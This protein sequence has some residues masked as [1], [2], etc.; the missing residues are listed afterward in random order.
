MMLHSIHR[1]VNRK[2]RL[3]I[4]SASFSLGLFSANVSQAQ[5]YTNVYWNPT[6]NG[7]GGTGLWASSSNFWSTNIAGGGTLSAPTNNFI[8]NFSGT[9]GTVTSASSLTVGGINFLTN[10]YIFAGT[11]APKTY[12]GTDATA[13]GTNAI[14]IGNNVNLSINVNS[15][16]GFNF[17][18][19]AMTG[20]TGSTVTLIGAAGATNA[21]IFGS[22]SA[23]SGR[24]NSVNT[25]ISGAGT[26][27]L[28][29]GG[30]Q[31]FH[32]S[33]HYIQHQ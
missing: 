28:G 30:G 4:L 33:R 21:I 25:I 17:N 7:L 12:T 15:T 22:T 27:V 14:N 3:C 13:T 8:Y 19:L 1:I 16:N 31:R 29:S 5:T 24:T 23:N 10:G 11:G 18:G 20:G 32:S 6:T 26:I 2:L 9:G